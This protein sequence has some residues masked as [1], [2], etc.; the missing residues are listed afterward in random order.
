MLSRENQHELAV[1]ARKFANLKLF[2]C[3]WFLNNPSIVSEMTFERLELLGLLFVPQHS[4]ARVLDQVVYKWRHSKKTIADVLVTKY[5]DLHD[6]GWRL[7][8]S[9]V[10]RDVNMLFSGN[11][12]TWL[13]MEGE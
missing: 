9:D 7:T 4:D 1:L 3:W 13:G 6:S 12:K 10:S 8:A 2:G 11:A 5:L